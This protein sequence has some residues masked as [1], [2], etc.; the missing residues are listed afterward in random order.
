MLVPQTGIQWQTVSMMFRS[1]EESYEQM[2]GYK[3]G[4][5]TSE[6]VTVNHITHKT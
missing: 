5:V 4:L 6:V 3:E 2:K 1:L